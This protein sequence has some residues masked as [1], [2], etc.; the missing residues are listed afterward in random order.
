[1]TNIF[2]ISGVLIM[3]ALTGFLFAA[4]SDGGDPAG[5]P[6]NFPGLTGS[7]HG[8]GETFTFDEKA[9]TFIKMNDDGWGEKGDLAWTS[10]KFTCV[11][12]QK[13]DDGVSWGQPGSNAPIVWVRPYSINGNIIKI[14]DH[15]YKKI[16]EF[17]KI[18]GENPY[19]ILAIGNSF[20]QNAM[21]YMRDMLIENGVPDEKIALVN[22]Y[23]GGQTLQGHASN[24]ESNAASYIRQS[25]GPD[26]IIN[27]I[28]NVTL[29]SLIES[30]NWDYITLQQGSPISGM[31][32]TYN[33]DIDKLIAYIRANCTNPNVKIGWHM[34]WAY[35]AKEKVSSDVLSAYNTN[36]SGSQM[37]MYTMIVNSVQSKILTNSDFDFI[38][39]SGTAIQNA[40]DFYGD[41]MNGGDGYHLN[42]KGQFIAGAMWLR[43]IY[44]MNI[45][46]F[47]SYVA[48]DTAIS[49]TDIL[50][51]KKCVDDAFNDPFQVTN[52]GN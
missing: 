30:N 15:N 18:S 49:K 24:A 50:Q 28:P 52:Q 33:D 10:D 3:A 7:W 21:R 14:T 34:T 29:K 31:V 47:D 35:A 27:R 22:A 43:Q 39:P 16:A 25:F 37:T 36:Y 4:C 42:N 32:A 12:R 51:I 2:R 11:I 46:V 19:R 41:V 8:Q 17:D 38:I 44:N 20:S 1:M 26:G 5:T 40:R 23:I 48:S 6:D 9:K 13:T 45:D